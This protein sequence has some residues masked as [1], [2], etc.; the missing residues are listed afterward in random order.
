MSERIEMI[1]NWKV[2]NLIAELENG[3]LRIP[4]FQREY[5]WEPSKV[6]KLLNSI[7]REYP[8]GSF[9][10]WETDRQMQ[11]FSREV[12][13]L[14][15]PAQP[16]SGR[17]SFILDG[18]Q[19][20]TSLYVGLRGLQLNNRDYSKIC[21]S[22][23]RKEFYIPRL[24]AEENDIAAYRLYHPT[25]SLKIVA[26]YSKAGKYQYVAEIINCSHLLR[27]YPLS[28]IKSV[29][30][31]LDEVVEIFERIN[32]GGKRLS[33][34]DLVHASVWSND[35][36]LREKI[37]EFNTEPAIKLFGEVSPEVF[38]HSL[39]LN[40]KHDCTN[41]QQLEL[42]K[43]DCRMCWS[44]TVD[45]IRLAIDFIKNYGVQQFAII[46]YANLIAVIQH[47]FFVSDTDMIGA[48][49]KALISDWMWSVSFSQ[50]YSSSALTRMKEDADWIRALTLGVK[51]PRVFTVKLKLADL[52][53]VRMNQRS[54][55]KNGILCIMAMNGPRDFDNGNHVTLDKTNASRSNSKENHHFFPF[56]LCESFSVSKAEINS[57]LNFAFISKRLNLDI[58]NKKP[59][60]YLSKYNA[61]NSLLSACLETHYINSQALDAAMN[62][63]FEAFITYRGQSLLA[64]IE[65]LCH[66]NDGLETI[67]SGDV[68]P[69]E[70]S[71]NS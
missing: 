26:E 36:D 13:G 62:D 10:L 58:L 55:I 67:N 9:F 33:L 59:S 29:K 63:D 1:T 19:R 30:M 12:P 41:R 60:A 50:R 7:Y 48:E 39:A 32:Q 43:E 23:E 38:T 35:F 46:P 8:I 18:Q 2:S 14:N 40:I 11:S 24:R 66:V 57:V 28:V 61:Q 44:R 64:K 25:E 4:R 70:E 16:E 5:V 31:G 56:S 47:Y 6:V 22:L 42:S 49:D 20:I 51:K 34:F 69:V 17:F 45:C 52:I 71:E 54:V 65:E 21:F 15:F 3:N 53:K 27:E 68:L 37:D